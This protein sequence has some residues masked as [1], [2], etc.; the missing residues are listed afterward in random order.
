MEIVAIF[1][2]AYHD[3]FIELTYK[4]VQ[5]YS[6]AFTRGAVGAAAERARTRGHGDWIID[7]VLL[8]DD[9]S[10]SHEI[11]F[12][13]SSRWEIRCKDIVYRWQPK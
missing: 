2:G 5:A 9:G 7:E 6:L 13:L 1:L 12:D 3:G 11:E 10:V 8:A 4:H